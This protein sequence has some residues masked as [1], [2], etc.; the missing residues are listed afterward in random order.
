MHRAGTKHIVHHIEKTRRTDFRHI[1]LHLYL[2]IIKVRATKNRWRHQD[3]EAR[4]RKEIDHRSP[5]PKLETFRAHLWVSGSS[6]R[7]RKF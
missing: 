2:C 3:H 6:R 1:Q 7:D 5:E 4:F